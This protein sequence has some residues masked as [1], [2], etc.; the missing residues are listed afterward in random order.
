MYNKTNDWDRMKI[1]MDGRLIQ[2]SK[3]RFGIKR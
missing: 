2:K 3:N 1:I